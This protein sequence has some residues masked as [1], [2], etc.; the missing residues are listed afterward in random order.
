MS[1]ITPSIESWVIDEYSKAQTL[2]EVAEITN[3]S[4]GSVYNII[5]NGRADLEK[6]TLMKLENFGAC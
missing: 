6:A 1:K 4:K 3:L 2:D 5:K